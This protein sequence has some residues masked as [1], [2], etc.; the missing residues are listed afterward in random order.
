MKR[1]L[2]EMFRTD[3]Q[4]VESIRIVGQ[5]DSATVYVY[6]VIDWIGV[7]AEDFVKAINGLDVKTIHLRVNSPG[8]DVFDAR[9]IQTALK[10]HPARV[11]AHIDGMAASAAAFLVMAA[12]EVEMARGAFFMIHNAWTVARGDAREL[13]Q[14]ADLLDKV[15]ASILEDFARK[16]GLE[17]DLITEMMDAET[18]LNADEALEWGFV[19]RVFDGDAAKNSFDLSVYRNAPKELESQ[20]DITEE[21]KPKF[22]RAAIERRMDFVERIG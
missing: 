20:A 18:W 5:G 11:V 6:D 1:F 9:A 15:N 12:D 19:D 4:A 22:D 8:G 13:R 21:E 7:N 17:N 14:V 3:A 16:T 10:A 2:R